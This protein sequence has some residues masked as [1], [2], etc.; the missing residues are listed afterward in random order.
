MHNDA[1]CRLKDSANGGEGGRRWR[2][3]R[4]R[5]SYTHKLI[6]PLSNDRKID[7]DGVYRRAHRDGTVVVKERGG[8]AGGNIFWW[9][10]RCWVLI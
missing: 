7:I 8:L 1:S 5:G 10:L 3:G 9:W 2:C 4:R 6:L